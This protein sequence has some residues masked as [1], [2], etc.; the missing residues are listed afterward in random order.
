MKY[1][2]NFLEGKNG[3]VYVSH[4]DFI[5]PDACPEP[6]EFCFFTGQERKRDMYDLLEEIDVC[7][8]HPV[9]VR[10]HQL[11]PGVGGYKPEHLLQA[12]QQVTITRTGILLCKACRCHGVI[13]GVIPRH[14][15]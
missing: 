2:P 15:D 12:L 4:A 11:A 6:N 13:T 1:L 8:F 14:L 10:S 3:D 7:G 9:V 5:C